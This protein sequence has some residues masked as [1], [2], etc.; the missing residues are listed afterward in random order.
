MNKLEEYFINTFKRRNKTSIRNLVNIV[1]PI[2]NPLPV[3]KWGLHKKHLV[4]HIKI[5]TNKF[6]FSI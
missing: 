4:V 5:V 1:N 6:A 3:K 2:V